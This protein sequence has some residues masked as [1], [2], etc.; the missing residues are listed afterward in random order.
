MIQNSLKNSKPQMIL[1]KK[2]NLFFIPGICHFKARDIFNTSS[3]VPEEF[4]QKD[5]SRINYEGFFADTLEQLALKIIKKES[6]ALYIVLPE[7]EIF[8]YTSKQGL[9]SHVLFLPAHLIHFYPKQK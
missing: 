7:S 8:R 5:I 3:M 4:M 2:F 9:K 1:Q 6:S